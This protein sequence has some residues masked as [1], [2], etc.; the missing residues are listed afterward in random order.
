MKKIIP[1]LLLFISVHAFS[2]E[3]ADGKW[4]PMKITVDGLGSEWSSPLRFYNSETSLFFAMLNDST[5]LYLCFEVRDEETQTKI[6]EAGMRIELKSK[7]KLKCDASVDFPLMEKTEKTPQH[8]D[9]GDGTGGGR[10]RHAETDDMRTTFILQNVNLMAKG[11][12]TQ[13]GLLPIKDSAGLEAALNWDSKG[14]MTYEL[15]IPL[16]ELFG[17]A[18][19]FQDVTKALTMRVEVNAFA[20]PESSGGGGGGGGMGGGGMPG[21]GGGGMGGMTGTMPPRG[22][23]GHHSG[24]ANSPM[25]EVKTL[26][27]GFT[28]ATAPPAR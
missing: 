18:F 5:D 21:G 23:G 4:R 2:Q 26:K 22:G 25:Y 28:L 3:T 12:A 24:G 16:K 27:Q 11:F 6:N 7:G 17:P 19:S 14:M 20:R 13:N 1:V 15:K 9:M 8:E 10:K